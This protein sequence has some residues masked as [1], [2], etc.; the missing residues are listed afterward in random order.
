M[1]LRPAENYEPR[2]HNYK[3]QLNNS[4]KDARTY[5]SK[6]YDSKLA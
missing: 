1:L 3:K 2:I 4:R 5:Q 6:G